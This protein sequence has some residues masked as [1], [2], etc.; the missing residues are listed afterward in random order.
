MK[1]KAD[2]NT[3]CNKRVKFFL[4]DKDKELLESGS[5]RK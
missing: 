5:K 2:I 3:P 1:R 4:L